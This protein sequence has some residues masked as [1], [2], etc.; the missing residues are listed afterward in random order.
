MDNPESKLLAAGILSL[1]VSVLFFVF[2][3]NT[4]GGVFAGIGMVLIFISR[5]DHFEEFVVG[6]VRAKTRDT[7][8]LDYK[9]RDLENA[10]SILEDKYEKLELEIKNKEQEFKKL[11]KKRDREWKTK[12]DERDQEILTL[13]RKTKRL[14]G[15][16]NTINELLEESNSTVQTI[17][18]SSCNEVL[19]KVD[20]RIVG[21]QTF[22]CRK[23]FRKT[24]VTVRNGRISTS[25]IPNN[26]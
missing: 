13:E 1:V 6:K 9:V 23:C 19:E 16:L 12:V 18:C 14:T 2:G 5:S 24:Y 22:G 7:T 10:K 25:S 26:F 20:A 21:N 4:P 3:I 17:R 11:S 15:G 8:K